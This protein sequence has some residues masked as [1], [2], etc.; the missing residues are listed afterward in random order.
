MLLLLLHCRPGN[1]TCHN[2]DAPHASPFYFCN[3][4]CWVS[5]CSGLLLVAHAQ[6]CRKAP[7][8]FIRSVTSD[9]TNLTA[10]HRRPSQARILLLGRTITETAVLGKNLPTA[11]WQMASMHV[12]S[13]QV[14][15][16]KCEQH[17]CGTRRD[18]PSQAC[19]DALRLSQSLVRYEC[20]RG[21]IAKTRDNSPIVSYLVSRL[22]V[23]TPH[24][25]LYTYLPLHIQRCLLPAG[26]LIIQQPAGLSPNAHEK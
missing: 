26:P 3:F 6:P 23:V 24:L 1:A 18:Q 10:T 5:T 8:L 20:C 25:H 22:S 9:P 15:T 13:N 17:S 4:P 7:N 12:P 2:L 21:P 19:P 16:R 11:S 14:G